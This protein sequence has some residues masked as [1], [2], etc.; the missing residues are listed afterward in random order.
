MPAIYLDYNS[1]TPIGPAIRSAM[2]PFLGPNY[3]NASS[4]HELGRTSKAAVDAARSQVAAI[5]NATPEE[6]VFTGGG[7][8]ANNF[9]I[10]GV[11]LSQ[12]KLARSHYITSA[13]EHPSVTKPLRFL[14]RMGCKLTVVPVDSHGMV[15]P[16][17]IRRAI[18]K[19]TM[20][21]SV[22]HSNN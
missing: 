22:M 7:S 21:I 19:S 2:R 16:D 8:E 1:T 10:K 18:N 20:L 17:D 4:A 5:L 13:V 11:A 6:I 3:G 14:E 15:N 9:A 12:D